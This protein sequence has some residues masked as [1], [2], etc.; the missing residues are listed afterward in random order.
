MPESGVGTA[1][2]LNGDPTRVLR[3]ASTVEA[4]RPVFS[5]EWIHAVSESKPG[6]FAQD[7]RYEL[8]LVPFGGWMVFDTIIDQPTEIAGTALFGLTRE[9][10]RALCRKLNRERGTPADMVMDKGAVA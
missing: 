1:L 8:L 3:P 2:D 10:G 5:A 6:R 4:P 7:A 9:Q